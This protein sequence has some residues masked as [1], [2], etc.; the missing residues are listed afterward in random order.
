MG[1]LSAHK[2]LGAG[3]IVVWSI[4]R[5]VFWR[6]SGARRVVTSDMTR[7]RRALL[8]LVSLS[9]VPIYLSYFTPLL[10][11]FSLPWPGWIGWAGDVLLAAAV[12]LFVWSHAA[13][14]AGWTVSVDVAEGQRLVTSGPYR[15]VRHPM[16]SSLIVMAVALGLATANLLVALPFGIAILAMYLDRVDAEERLMTQEFG[17]EYRDYM[18]RTGRVLPRLSG[19]WARRTG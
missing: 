18:A 17:D 7:W 11:R 14:G 4:S 8:A 12:G 2:L 1:A 10:D 9:L 15:F 19:R 16:Y 6:A 5:V 13:L 3:L